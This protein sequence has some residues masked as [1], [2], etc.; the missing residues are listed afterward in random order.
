VV[1]D[2]RAKFSQLVSSTYN[3][4]RDNFMINS[5]LNS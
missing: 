5:L 2:A 1:V 3:K 4:K